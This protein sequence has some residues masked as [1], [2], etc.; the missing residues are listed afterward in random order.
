MAGFT[1]RSF[2]VALLSVLPLLGCATHPPGPNPTVVEKELVRNALNEL[3]AAVYAIQTE[4]ADALN[5]FSADEGWT[6]A[7]QINLTTSDAARDLVGI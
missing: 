6:A 5:N 7:I 4:N 3:C 2:V 1:M